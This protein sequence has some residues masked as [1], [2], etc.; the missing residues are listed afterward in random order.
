MPGCL[1]VGIIGAGLIG[2]KRA[3][4]LQAPSA[5]LIAVADISLEKA[6]SLASAYG[7]EAHEDW[8]FVV[9]SS[10]VDAVIVAT[11]NDIIPTCAVAALRAGKH[12]FVEK[13]AGRNPQDL[14]LLLKA[15]KEARG[16]L[17]VGFNKRFH[18]GFQKAKAMIAEGAIGDLMYLRARYGHGG[19]IGYDREWRAEPERSG[20]GELLDQGVHLLDLCRWL[21]GEF[22]LEFGRV[23]TFF[24]DMPVEDNG[25][26]YLKSPDKKRSAF[27]HASCTEW[28]NLF[29]FEIFGRNGKLQVW[30]LGRSYGEEELRY[31]KM[32]PQMGPPEVSIYKFPGP[33]GSW[34]SEW[35]AFLAEISGEKT[36]LAKVQ[37]AARAIDLVYAAYRQS[38]SPWANTSVAIPK[39]F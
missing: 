7:A 18:P 10:N 15:S 25:F 2:T 28:K 37:D 21:G 24:W 22:E 31:F 3:A 30:G 17:R 13:P 19:R 20:G 12:V 39:S 36:E 29:D 23:E 27:L 9:N 8:N 4:T 5:K 35:N 38:S 33:D 26:L 6:R 1:K 14:S 34:Q 32:L 16:I 11:S